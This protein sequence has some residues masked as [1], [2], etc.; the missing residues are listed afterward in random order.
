MA[1]II[2]GLG[3]PGEEYEDTR[4]NTGRL[5][6]ESFSKTQ[7]FNEWKE[8]VPAKAL[9]SKGAVGKTLA[10][11]VLPNAFMN[12]SGSSVSKF[13]KGAKAAERLVVVCD[14]LDLPLGSF[15]ISFDRGSGGHKGIESIMRALKTKKFYRVR[16]GISPST[17]SGAIRKPSGEKVVLNFILDHWKPHEI[18]TLKAVFKK[19][20]LALE[21]LVA[22]GAARAMN[23]FN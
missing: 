14:D 21:T 6:V 17:V 23:R 11:L 8:N 3:N 20:S 5:A 2:A 22:E 16:I 15:K 12:K 19:T 9:V 1:W 10:A 13:V 4:H 18:A 7:K